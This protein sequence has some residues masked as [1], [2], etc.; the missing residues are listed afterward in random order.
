MSSNAILAR[1][2]LTTNSTVLT[3]WATDRL[4]DGTNCAVGVELLADGA[5]GGNY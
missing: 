3:K 2:E 5:S 4:A 1:I